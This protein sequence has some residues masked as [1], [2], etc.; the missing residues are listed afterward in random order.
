MDEGLFKKYSVSIKN[1]QDSKKEIIEYIKEKT[2]V[3]LTS[4]EVSLSKKEITVFT[5]SVKKSRLSQKNIKALLE[6]KGYR[7]K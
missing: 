1:Q 7:L 3:V 6:E 5:T 2:G 4:E